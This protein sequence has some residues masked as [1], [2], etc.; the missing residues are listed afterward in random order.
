MASLESG[1][2]YFL[3]DTTGTGNVPRASKLHQNNVLTP[4]PNMTRDL[5]RMLEMALQVD[6]SAEKM[7]CRD[8]FRLSTI[9][10]GQI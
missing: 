3:L 4:I 6:S 7:H 5:Q 8:C 9:D 10:A 1:V 2:G